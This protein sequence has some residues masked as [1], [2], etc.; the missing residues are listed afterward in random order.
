MPKKLTEKQLRFIENYAGNASEAARLAGYPP[1]YASRIGSE[2]MKDPRI[3]L[4]IQE[5]K[6]KCSK[7][8]TREERQIFWT[9][10]VN[11]ETLPIETRLRASELLG[12]SEADFTDKVTMDAKIKQRKFEEYSDA[13]LVEIMADKYLTAK[14]EVK[15]INYDNNKGGNNA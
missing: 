3:R 6:T 11:D 2:L 7:I 1:K 14:Q 15:K 12:K 10:I 13:E 9:S 8:M 5:R 4:K